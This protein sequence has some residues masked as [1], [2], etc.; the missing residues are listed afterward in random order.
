MLARRHVRINIK[1][2]CDNIEILKKMVEVGLGLSLVPRFSVQSL[3]A[4]AAAF[5]DTSPVLAVGKGFAK[6]IGQEIR[7]LREGKRS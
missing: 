3:Y 7:W 6:A 5:T 4:I 1:M 2:Q